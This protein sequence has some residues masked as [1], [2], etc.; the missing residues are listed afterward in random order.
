ML[1]YYGA[2]I[3]SRRWFKGNDTTIMAKWLEWKVRRLLADCDEAVETPLRVIFDGL[4]GIN[5]CLSALY[6][7][8]LWIAPSDALGIARSGFVFLSSLTQAANHFL[9]AS[10]PR[11]KLNPKAHMFSHVM[12]RLWKTGSQGLTS[13]NILA[14]SCQQDED[15]VGRISFQS[16]QVSIR[17]VHARTLQRYCLNLGLRW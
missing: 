8:P 3:D 1:A 14:E 4:A 11:Y 6:H 9:Q 7:Q 10:R 17:T 12:H 15:F 13:L 5:A 2:P 16:R